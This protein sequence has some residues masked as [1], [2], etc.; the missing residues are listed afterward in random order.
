MFLI[1][2]AIL[3]SFT[4]PSSVG[5]LLS[6]SRDIENMAAMVTVDLEVYW[7]I[8]A[9]M[10]CE[11]IDW[12]TLNPGEEKTITVFVKNTGGDAITGSFEVSGWDP[13]E[14][15][16]YITL[17]WD[18]AATPLQPGR[19]RETHFTLTVSPDITGITNF[20]FTITVTGTQYIP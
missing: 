3:S 14:T 15:G 5:G 9:T 13:P 20:Y 16:A 4:I 11:R 18:F 19:I 10:R 8:T 17:T 7:D 12:G 6:V 1:P 2:F